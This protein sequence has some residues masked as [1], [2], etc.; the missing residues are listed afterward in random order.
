MEAETGV[1][2]GEVG[3]GEAEDWVMM[4]GDS[5]AGEGMERSTLKW[6]PLPPTS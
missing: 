5:V 2:A 3:S 1:M 6:S 4:V